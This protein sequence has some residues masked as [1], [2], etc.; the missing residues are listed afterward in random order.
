MRYR[1]ALL[2]KHI[3]HYT[4]HQGIQIG[5]R[6]RSRH[7]GPNAQCGQLQPQIN[8]LTSAGHDTIPLYVLGGQQK[9]RSGTHL[10][11]VELCLGDRPTDRVYVLMIFEQC[12]AQ[13][14]CDAS[15]DGSKCL[16]LP[17]VFVAI[18]AAQHEMQHENKM[19]SLSS[20]QMHVLECTW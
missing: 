16:P 3:A 8:Y 17:D 18:C 2:V 5:K 13:T 20:F 14:C 11:S 1:Q 10:S 9:F 19:R 6:S 15:N 4:P 7:M 12:C